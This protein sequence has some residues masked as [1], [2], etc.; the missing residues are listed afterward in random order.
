MLILSQ[1]FDSC[2]YQPTVSAAREVQDIRW[3]DVFDKIS[4]PQLGTIT[5]GQVSTFSAPAFSK[6]YGC[7]QS[8]VSRLFWVFAFLEKKIV[9]SNGRGVVSRGVSLLTKPLALLCSFVIIWVYKIFW[10]LQNCKNY[11]GHSKFW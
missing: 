2:Q 3:G 8:G 10:T 11:R 9:F 7:M 1:C 5:N 6:K 4:L